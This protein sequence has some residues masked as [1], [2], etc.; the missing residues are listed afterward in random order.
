MYRQF[1]ES[2]CLN[3]FYLKQY[4]VSRSCESNSSLF[5]LLFLSVHFELLVGHHWWKLNLLWWYRASI[6]DLLEL[7]SSE[8]VINFLNECNLEA[9]IAVGFVRCTIARM[10]AISLF[11]LLLGWASLVVL[12]ELA[13]G[14]SSDLC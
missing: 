5:L 11:T 9:E 13:H 12:V 7:L 2:D 4:I 1:I 8:L 3:T 6:A 14:A 10:K